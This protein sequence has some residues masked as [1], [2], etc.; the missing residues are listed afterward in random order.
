MQTLLQPKDYLYPRFSV[1]A[2]HYLVILASS[3]PDSLGPVSTSYGPLPGSQ[4]Y[5]LE[6]R[7]ATPKGTEKIGLGKVKGAVLRLRV[8]APPSAFATSKLA[9]ASNVIRPPSLA[10][11]GE[12]PQLD[13]SMLPPTPLHS[14]ALHL[15]SLSLLTDHLKYHHS[16]STSYPAYAASARLL[17]AWAVKRGYD[18]SLGLTS[19]WWAWCVARSLNAGGKSAAGDSASL[20][21]GGEAWAG[22]RK[23]VEWLAGANWTEGIFF[24]SSAETVR[25]NPLGLAISSRTDLVRSH[26]TRRINSRRL[27]RAVR[28]SSTLPAPSTSQPVST[29]RR[30]R[31]SSMTHG[32][33]SHCC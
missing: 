10:A 11:D 20:A 5:A 8:V 12:N 25:K 31:C 33:P 9:P 32:P 23:A 26:S 13:P 27:T 24:K 19:E 21:A 29:S 3:L 30:S 18:A 28:S 4:G 15:S 16:L 1:K 14:S 22:W 6:V 2:L 7:S 17:Q